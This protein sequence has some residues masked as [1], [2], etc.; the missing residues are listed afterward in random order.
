MCY[1]IQIETQAEESVESLFT[2]PEL[3]MTLSSPS[4]SPPREKVVSDAATGK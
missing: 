2:S 1:V 4:P 3:P